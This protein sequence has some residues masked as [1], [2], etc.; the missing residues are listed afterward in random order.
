VVLTPRA[1]PDPGAAPC[2]GTTEGEIGFRP[3]DRE[4]V[5]GPGRYTTKPRAHWLPDLIARYGLT[6][7]P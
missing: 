3:G 6:P 5:L 7:Q 2:G 4:V 1:P